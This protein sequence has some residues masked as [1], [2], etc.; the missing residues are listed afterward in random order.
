L[1]A[2]PCELWSFNLRSR[3]LTITWVTAVLASIFNVLVN[4]IALDAIAWKYYFV[5]LVVIAVYGVTV[6]FTYP[7]T[8]GLTLEEA[9][10]L[11]DDPGLVP[12][13]TTRRQD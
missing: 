8:A 2:Y 11:M 13:K 12:W 4:P 1:V 10:S 9:S 6:F 7:E 3:G 5:F